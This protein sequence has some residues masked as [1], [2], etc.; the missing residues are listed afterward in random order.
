MNWGKQNWTK[1]FLTVFLF[2]FFERALSE[3]TS[4][5]STNTKQN[6][7]KK[8]LKG[9]PKYTSYYFEEIDTCLRTC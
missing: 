3:E 5:D 4:I 6:W 8:E 9:C 1:I 7:T 2:L